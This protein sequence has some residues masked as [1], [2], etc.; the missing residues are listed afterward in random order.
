MVR[1][2]KD[3]LGRVIK[4]A[5]LQMGLTREV[6]AE[7]IGLSP[8]YIMSIENENRKPAFDKLYKIIRALGIRSDD[9]F[10]PERAGTDTQAERLSR[11]LPQCD[12]RDIRAITALVET[13]ITEKE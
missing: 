5:R 12:E 10:Y 2:D 1:N 9:I 4:N 11:L 7:M 3:T 8:R 13:F 6:F